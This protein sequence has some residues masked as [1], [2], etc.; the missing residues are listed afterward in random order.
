MPARH[1]V[2]LYLTIKVHDKRRGDLSQAGVMEINSIAND[3]FCSREFVR[4]HATVLR[5]PLMS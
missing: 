1:W 4:F 3:I 5:V 2:A